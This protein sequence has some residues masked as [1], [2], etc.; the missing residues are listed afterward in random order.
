MA[1]GFQPLDALLGR[2]LREPRILAAGGRIARLRAAWAEV[3]GEPIA[4]HTAAS[5][6]QGKALVVHVDDPAWLTELNFR[7]AEL[8]QKIHAWAEA[9]WPTDLR[10]VLH[11]LEATPPPE[12]E[13]APPPPPSPARRRA[14]EAAAA[15]VEDEALRKIIARALAVQRTEN[16]E[17]DL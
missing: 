13:V 2:V 10:L 11:P 6:L 9:P 17:P 4:V 8:L 3:V 14:A 7:R 12:P 1:R 15:E 5:H 16:D